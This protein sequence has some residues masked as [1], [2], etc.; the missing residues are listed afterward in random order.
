MTSEIYT[1]QNDVRVFATNHALFR[2]LLFSSF[3]VCFW[4]ETIEKDFVCFL[5]LSFLCFFLFLLTFL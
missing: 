3:F 2:P 4:S 1:S 5:L